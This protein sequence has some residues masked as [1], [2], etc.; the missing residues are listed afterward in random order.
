MDDKELLALLIDCPADGVRAAISLYGGIAKAAAIRIL[1]SGHPDIEEC[2]ADTFIKLWKNVKA[3]EPSFNGIKAYISVI[4]RNTAIDAYRKNKTR[5]SAL[6]LEDA[7]L[8]L[9]YNLEDEYERAQN[10]KIVKESVESLPEPDRTIFFRRYFFA[11]RVKD[12]ALSAGMDIKKVENILY[13][14]KKK[15]EQDLLERGVIR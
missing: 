11:E 2:V 13:R 14:G 8:E 5:P 9:D 4:A 3:S 15:L 1:G 6:P 7:V 10:A 12:I